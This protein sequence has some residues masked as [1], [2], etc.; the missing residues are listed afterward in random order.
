MLRDNTIV[1]DED[2]AGSSSS[3][4]SE[5]LPYLCKKHEDKPIEFYC[6]LEKE[7]LCSNC[8][9]K[10]SKD[11]PMK[12]ERVTAHH[13]KRHARKLKKELKV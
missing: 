13:I 11:H 4:Y 5:Q 3:D 7:F 1:D 6:N 9:L 8:V 2:D 12:V 10:H